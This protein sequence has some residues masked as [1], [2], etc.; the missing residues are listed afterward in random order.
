MERGEV[1]P[2]R[3]APPWL[4]CHSRSCFVLDSC[5]AVTWYVL[6]QLAGQAKQLTALLTEGYLTCP[7]AYPGASRKRKEYE[8][9][10]GKWDLEQAA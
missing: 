8:V 9:A 3:S 7:A 6:A 10:P 5:S 2:A 1:E 4:I